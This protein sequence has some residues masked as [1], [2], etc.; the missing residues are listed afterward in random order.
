MN[1]TP[2]AGFEPSSPLL[3]KAFA[4]IAVVVTRRKARRLDAAQGI[5]PRPLREPRAR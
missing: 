1:R 3:R 2:N 5:A 4:V